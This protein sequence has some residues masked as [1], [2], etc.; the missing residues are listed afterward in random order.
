MKKFVKKNLRAF[1]FALISSC[2]AFKVDAQQSIDFAMVSQGD[3]SLKK[4]ECSSTA[5]DKVANIFYTTLILVCQVV[6][7][8]SSFLMS[9]RRLWK[10]QVL[11][12]VILR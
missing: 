5:P 3:V 7:P 4:H 11:L 2:F 10:L 9:S 6:A 12:L 8:I 1:F